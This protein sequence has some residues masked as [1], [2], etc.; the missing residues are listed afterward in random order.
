LS[1]AHLIV[2]TGGPTGRHLRELLESSGA[3]IFNTF[4]RTG[5]P[6]DG[7]STT[8]LQYDLLEPERHLPGLLEAVS[9][10][11]FSNLVLFAHP[12]ISRATAEAPL[13][14]LLVQARGLKGIGAILNS[15]LPRLAPGGTVLFV[16]PDLTSIRAPGYLSARTYF[17]GLKGLVEEYARVTRPPKGT[18]VLVSVLHMPG[19]THPHVSADTIDRMGR[20]TL[21]GRL[22]DGKDLAVW[23]FDL[24]RS[25]NAWMHGKILS[26]QDGPL[27]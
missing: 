20:Q 22:P 14:D 6:Q 4:Y 12:T 11:T 25:S 13:D 3:R 10:S 7:R 23:I 17:G 15:F 19:D 2:G 5:Q 26:L 16:V 18:I 24:L 21:T 1:D 8:W 27:F 9:G